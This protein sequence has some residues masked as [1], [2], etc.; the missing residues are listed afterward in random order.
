MN[1]RPG[2]P[3][4]EAAHAAA[5]DRA[6]SSDRLATYLSAVNGSRSRARL[7]Y[8]WDR[9]LASAVLADVAILE[10]ALRNAMDAALT[11]EWGPRW[12]ESAAPAL[13][14]RSLSQL[15][16]AWSDLP[17]PTKKDRSDPALP[18]R[19]VARCM[20]GFWVGLL[21]AGDHV[22]SDPRRRRVDYEEL[23]RRSLHR[24]FRGGRAE[25][26]AVGARF[27]RNWTHGL[28]QTVSALRNRAAHHEPLVAGFP[29]PGQ[30]VR[31]TTSDGHA[32]CLRLARV[33]DRDLAAWMQQ[34][35][36][37]PAILAA[38]P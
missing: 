25:A 9:D 38:R 23:W 34:N 4:L 13:D 7:L 17:A 24:A 19:L 6:I 20:L 8:V 3:S 33:I 1:L 21:D 37:V 28:A 15:R 11:Q 2:N 10:V 31:M 30:R 36:Q 12:Y 16:R 22:G 26:R 18:G 35:T 32:A 29:L 5:L 27:S 14:E